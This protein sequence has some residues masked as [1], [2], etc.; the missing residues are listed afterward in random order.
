MRHSV[1][2]L[3]LLALTNCGLQRAQVSSAA[4]AVDD[5]A[6][7]MSASDLRVPTV[8]PSANTAQGT[9]G[10]PASANSATARLAA[11]PRHG[12]WVKVAMGEGSTDSIMAWIVYPSTRT[13]APVVVVV[14][15]IF[16]L[17]TG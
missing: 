2:A 5:H 3:L 17:Q 4:A 1:F 8:T 13:R 9:A 12:E 7:H 11:S 14:H 10:I 15:E 16:G 6:E